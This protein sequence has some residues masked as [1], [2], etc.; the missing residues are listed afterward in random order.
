MTSCFHLRSLSWKVRTTTAGRLG[1]GLYAS[2]G[3]ANGLICASYR[4]DLG[5]IQAVMK[6]E[7]FRF[8]PDRAYHRFYVRY[9]AS[10][11]RSNVE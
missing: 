11:F 10:N 6:D 3:D 4:T 9:L 2:E 1:Y 7:G 8:D 5:G